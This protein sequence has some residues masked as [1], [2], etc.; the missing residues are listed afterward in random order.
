MEILN[1]EKKNDE[2]YLPDVNKTFQNTDEAS[3]ENE[4]TNLPPISSD[5]QKSEKDDGMEE[6]PQE[7]EKQNQTNDKEV[8]SDRSTEQQSDRDGQHAG[9]VEQATKAE[10]EPQVDREPQ[11]EY[12]DT[13]H[14]TLVTD[15]DEQHKND[16]ER[17]NRHGSENDG[18][19]S[20][21]D[22]REEDEHKEIPDETYGGL[23]DDYGK[24]SHRS[25]SS[26]SSRSEDS[27][28]AKED[29]K[30]EPVKQNQAQ[31]SRK[32]VRMD[33]SVKTN[34][35]STTTTKTK[36]KKQD[37]KKEKP[38]KKGE[39]SNKKKDYF[40]E[41]LRRL[42]VR[43]GKEAENIKKPQFK[44]HVPFVWTSLEPYY[45]TYVP[46]Y[47]INLPDE[48]LQPQRPVSRGRPPQGDDFHQGYTTRSTAIGLCD[49]W[50]DLRM[51]KNI[52]PKL[53][54]PKGQ[55][56]DKPKS[57]K[58]KKESSPK[59]GS[60]RLPKF[61]VV[62]FNSGKENATKKFPYNEVAKFRTELKDRFSSNA[63]KKVNKDYKRTKDDFYRMDLHKLDEIHPLNR[64]HMRRTYFAYLQ[65]TPGSRK[66]VKDCVKT[67]D[68]DEGNEQDEQ[69]TPALEETHHQQA[70]AST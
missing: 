29:Q 58:K 63:K 16:T 33:D 15:T 66:A 21:V 2:S 30:T 13:Y 49:P 36:G 70:V 57:Q 54:Q 68:T 5:E 42:R 3:E 39:E 64:P 52:L 1:S 17:E 31:Q 53:E 45:N 11:Q 41:E 60:T 38:A 61:P 19:D 40:Q 9:E 69:E 7:E 20:V 47:L 26:M 50:I 67:L 25:D 12:D 55:G 18:R 35:T 23:Q 22:D 34:K 46:N 8:L 65:N 6:P 37:N 62:D 44:E 14:S 32:S 27:D 56:R 28:K 51:D 59:E 24:K 4:I 43:L 48:E 10:Q